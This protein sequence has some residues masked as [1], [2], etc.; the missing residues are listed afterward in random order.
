V[1]DDVK[2]YKKFER[3]RE[4]VSDARRD[5]SDPARVDPWAYIPHPYE[6]IECPPTYSL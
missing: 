1:E 6:P 2:E 3:A 4:E 5:V